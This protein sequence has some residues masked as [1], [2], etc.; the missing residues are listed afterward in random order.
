MR[1]ALAAIFCLLPVTF[2]G[3]GLAPDTTYDS[4]IPTLKAVVGHE[5]GD[6]VTTPDEVGQYLD[7]LVKAAPDR[8][9]LVQ[10]ATSWEGRPLRYLVVG[11]R[12]RMA[13]L[14]EIRR[15]MRTLAS[16]SAD[17][18]RLIPDLPVVVWLLHGIHGN[19]ITSADAAL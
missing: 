2:S 13:R 6:A 18:D 11:S 14:D 16:G 8:T 19:E 4:A 12:E 10:Y 1:L 3:Q 7:A 17:A 5:P 9:R 15:G